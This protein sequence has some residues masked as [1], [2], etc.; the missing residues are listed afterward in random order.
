MEFFTNTL[1]VALA[2]FSLFVILRPKKSPK[3]KEQKQ[4]ELKAYY[5][6]KLKN[7]LEKIDDAALRQEKKI[8][9]LKEYAKELRMNLF[10][11]EEEVKHLIETLAKI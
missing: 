11:D 1:I 7:E 10:F 5:T 6:Q 9:L 8:A 4:E 2:A 3:S